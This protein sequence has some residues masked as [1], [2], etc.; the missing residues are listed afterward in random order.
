MLRARQE[1]VAL[2][3][4][5]VLLQAEVH[6]LLPEALIL[7]ELLPGDLGARILGRR[8]GKL[9]PNMFTKAQTADRLATEVGSP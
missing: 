6:A 4:V 9:P 2:L 5:E 8:N 7:G 3:V 1:G